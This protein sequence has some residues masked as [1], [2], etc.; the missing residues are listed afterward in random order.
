MLSPTDA[1][2]AMA[3]S[4]AELHEEEAK[5]AP[6]ADSRELTLDRIARLKRRVG[7]TLPDEVLEAR[8]GNTDKVRSILT[9]LVKNNGKEHVN[10]QYKETGRALLHEAACFGHKDLC[11]MLLEEFGANVNRITLMGG[12]TPLHLAAL[13][14]HRQVCFFLLTRYGAD[15]NK[16]NK[17]KAT[18]LHYATQLSTV[19]TLCKFGADVTLRNVDELTPVQIAMVDGDDDDLI[20]YLF[21]VSEQQEREKFQAEVEAKRRVQEELDALKNEEIRK[22]RER[23]NKVIIDKAQKEY[24]AWRHGAGDHIEDHLHDEDGKEGVGEDESEGGEGGALD[25][26]HGT[27]DAGRELNEKPADKDAPL[28]LKGSDDPEDVPAKMGL[29]R[30]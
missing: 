30:G 12:D 10:R 22:E 15:P 6:D 25:L 7:F 29:V 21:K 18:P 1:N 16:C 13:N 26:Q 9:A 2:I 14:S 4:A 24:D 20:D 11:I 23:K 17:Y 19:K 8:R 3:G 28:A 27:N 5:G